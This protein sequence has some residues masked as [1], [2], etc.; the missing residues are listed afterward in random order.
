MNHQTSSAERRDTGGVQLEL[1]VATPLRE[2][3]GEVDLSL[4]IVATG[5]NNA[6]NLNQGRILNLG[7]RQERKYRML[8]KGD[9]HQEA[10]EPVPL[11]QYAVILFLPVVL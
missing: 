5:S 3:K 8:K 2:G 4:P 1:L 10:L 7:E 6:S 9:R 11:F